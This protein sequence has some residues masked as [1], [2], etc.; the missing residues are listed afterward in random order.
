MGPRIHHG[1]TAVSRPDQR[2]KAAVEELL[3]FANPLDHA[4]DRF[5][6]EHTRIGDV[7]VPAGERVLIATSSPTATRRDHAENLRA[8]L[9]TDWV[10]QSTFKACEDDFRPGRSAT[11]PTRRCVC[12]R[13]RASGPRA[14]PTWPRSWG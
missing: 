13:P 5:T 11:S 6:T 14:S 9:L 3:R 10:S 2:R 12:S 8:G 1:Y 7:L 4:T